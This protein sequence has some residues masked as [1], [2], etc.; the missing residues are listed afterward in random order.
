MRSELAV[1]W[2]NLFNNGHTQY[3]KDSW[4]KRLEIIEIIKERDRYTDKKVSVFARLMTYFLSFVLLFFLLFILVNK[5]TSSFWF[6]LVISLVFTVFISM[7]VFVLVKRKYIHDIKTMGP[8]YLLQKRIDNLYLLSEDEMRRLA[9][10]II[11]KMC[12]ADNFE[13]KGA[14]LLCG[15]NPVAFLNTGDKSI[16]QCGKIRMLMQMGYDKVIAV[17]TEEQRTFIQRQYPDNAYISLPI[18]M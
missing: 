7:Q 5:Y 6:S 13:E 4:M 15:G 17:C 16:R 2:N 11:L 14:F 9:C 3:K 18:R 12:N 1:H 10:D 8:G